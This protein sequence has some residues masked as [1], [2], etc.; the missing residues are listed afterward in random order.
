[1]QRRTL[2]FIYHEVFA[3]PVEICCF[4]KKKNQNLKGCVLRAEIQLQLVWIFGEVISTSR[5]NLD[6]FSMNR[7]DFIL[8]GWV[9]SSIYLKSLLLSVGDEKDSIF[10]C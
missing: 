6:F 5:V 7:S 3:L 4:R 2:T 9:L 8:N 10:H 1:M